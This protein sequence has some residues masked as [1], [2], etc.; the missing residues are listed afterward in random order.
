[1]KQ[2]ATEKGRKYD[3]RRVGKT[4]RK[5]YL[6]YIFFNVVHRAKQL[7]KRSQVEQSVR[8]SVQTTLAACD[9]TDDEG[10]VDESSAGATLAMLLRLSQD[11]R[12]ETRDLPPSGQSKLPGIIG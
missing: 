6:L 5:N 8:L 1:M 7:S 9:E 4:V 12:M 10:E 11:P 2:F 3:G